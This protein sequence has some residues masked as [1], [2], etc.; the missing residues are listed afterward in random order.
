MQKLA[1]GVTQP[2]WQS[3]QAKGGRKRISFD[4]PRAQ[5]AT[6]LRASRARMSLVSRPAV[7]HSAVRRITRDSPRGRRRDRSIL[8][9]YLVP[10]MILPH[11]LARRAVRGPSG[12]RPPPRPT[13]PTPRPPPAPLQRRACADVQLRVMTHTRGSA[14]ALAQ[15]DHRQRPIRP[16]HVLAVLVDAVARV[17]PVALVLRVEAGLATVLHLAQP[18]RARMTEAEDALARPGCG[19]VPHNQRLGPSL[20]RPHRSL[21]V[22]PAR[23]SSS[24]H[25]RLAPPRVRSAVKSPESQPQEAKL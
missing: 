3:H 25:A 23:L 9:Y 24:S 2:R 14:P 17:L 21:P 11:S 8:S 1:E 22:A 5:R 15:I 4:E 20:A 10:C 19:G 12:A 13:A 6:A 18:R 7:L 16:S